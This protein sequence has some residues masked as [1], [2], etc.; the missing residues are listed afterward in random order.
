MDHR[1]GWHHSG[2]ACGGD[3]RAHGRDPG[4]VYGE[5]AREL[6]EPLFDRVDAPAT[7]SPKSDCWRNCLPSRF[8]T[9]SWPAKKFKT[10]S[11]TRQVTALRSAA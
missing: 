9:P 6:G 3:Q 11:A 2:P 8:G 1:Q 4:E 7:P 5:L 10:F